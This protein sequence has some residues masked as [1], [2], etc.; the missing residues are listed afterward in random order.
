[1][2]TERQRERE[3]R[4]EGGEREEKSTERMHR[5]T[6]RHT[7]RERER[8]TLVLCCMGKVKK[9]C[10]FFAADLSPSS[11][12]PPLPLYSF[13]SVHN[14]ADTIILIDTPVL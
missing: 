6:G 2:S 3:K 9:F 11:P 12:L 10:E 14:R 7:Q 5:Q 13:L 4:R 1:M 8:Q